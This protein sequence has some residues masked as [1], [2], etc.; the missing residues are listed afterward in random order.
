MKKT[1]LVTVMFIATFAF[2]QKELS[3][4]YDYQVSEPY[5]VVDSR[6][7]EYFSNGKEVL[8]VKVRAKTNEKFQ[9]ILQKYNVDDMKEI[10]KKGYNDFP[11]NFI[12]E[13]L[14]EAQGKFYLFYSSWTGKKTKQERLFYREVDFNAGTFTGKSK[15]VIN[16]D[17]Y[18]SEFYTGNMQG[19]A[20][21]NVGIG[22]GMNFTVGGVRKFNLSTSQDESKILIQ[23]RKKPK[24]RKDTKSWDIFNV[25]VY[26]DS[27]Q[28]KWNKQYTMPYTERRMDVLDNI[29]DN[30]G[31]LFM[32][33]KVFHD[34]SNKDKK[35]RKDK[36][37]NYH[38]E[39]FEMNSALEKI[40][41]SKISLEDKFINGISMF[42]SS[43]NEIICA[44]YYN[45][46][47]I[48]GAADG[49]FT[50]KIDQKGELIDRNYY[51]IPMEIV[52]QYM[53]ER[54][55]K[56]NTKRDK[57][58][59]A[60]ERI[61][62]LK[63][64]V[65]SND[66]SV[67]LI[68]EIT[69]IVIHRTSKGRVYYTYHY[70]DILIANINPKSELA[71]MKKIPKRQVGRQGKGGMSYTYFNTNG[72]HYLIYLDNIKN[73]NLSMD[74]PPALHSDGK[75]GFLTAMKINDA[76][77]EAVKG[78]V[79]DF[80]KIKGDIVAYQFNSDRVVKIKDNAFFVEVYKKKKEDVFLKV[81]MK[82]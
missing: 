36:K 73:F 76:T 34:D 70:D 58:G 7:K 46:G 42:P 82:K 25:A 39:L 74:K 18:L 1:I 22:F 41:I 55:K 38:I 67:T 48:L 45:R 51:P 12:Y 21:M 15:Q 64:L 60:N 4:D 63:E 79:L 9:I 43:N 66:G 32:M 78:S 2:A 47:K 27:M 13:G 59:K 68:G 35:R 44:G 29:V 19:A 14:V 56:K 5:R 8:G 16:H 50:Y 23:Y 6:N 72:N 52:N 62:T 11:K 3:D 30:N 10:G 40:K 71:W 57:K 69:Y 24:V 53:S 61:L 80:R 77:G 17:G 54:A 37:A 81:E 20:I 26:D 31:T 49:V 28:K 75:G 65:Y 33:T